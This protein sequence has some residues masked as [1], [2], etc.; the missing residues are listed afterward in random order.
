MIGGEQQSA[1][2]SHDVT[3][4]GLRAQIALSPCRVTSNSPEHSPAVAV[5]IIRCRIKETDI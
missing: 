5:D 1:R 2:A 3:I 4:L